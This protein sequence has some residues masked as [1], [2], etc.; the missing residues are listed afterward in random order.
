MTELLGSIYNSN[1]NPDAK[2][3]KE[4]LCSCSDC[5]FLALRSI[6]TSNPSPARGE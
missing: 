3:A 4:L 2:D 1:K 6:N 5:L